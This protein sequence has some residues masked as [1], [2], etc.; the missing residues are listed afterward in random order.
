MVCGVGVGDGS[1]SVQQVIVVLARA[2]KHM[3]VCLFVRTQAVNYFRIFQY[4]HN[5]HMHK[6]ML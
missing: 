5:V 1:G 3:F 6:R 4:S 2:A